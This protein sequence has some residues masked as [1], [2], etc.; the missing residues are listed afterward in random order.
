[1]TNKERK[2]CIE[3]S[4][5]NTQRSINAIEKKII[6]ENRDRLFLWLNDYRFDIIDCAFCMRVFEE[7][8]GFFDRVQE[9]VDFIDRNK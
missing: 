4:K 9:I 5:I 6:I 7:M 8:K 2:C 1:M 3:L